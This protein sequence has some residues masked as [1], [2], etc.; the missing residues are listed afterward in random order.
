MKVSIKSFDVQ[1]EVKNNGI[2]FEVADNDGNHLG[3]AIL[4][5]TGVIWCKGR[6]RRENGTK[7][8]WAKFIEI[9]DA[10]S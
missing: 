2:E 8:S 4:T 6:Q 7:I 9:M 5:K 10:Q 1:M 3:D